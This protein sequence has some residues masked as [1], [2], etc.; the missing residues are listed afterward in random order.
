MKLQPSVLVV[1]TTGWRWSCEST[2]RSRD[3]SWVSMRLSCCNA[4]HSNGNAK[5]LSM[6]SHVHG[7]C[8]MAPASLRSVSTWVAEPRP[9]PT[10]VT[11]HRPRFFEPELLTRHPTVASRDSSADIV[12]REACIWVH[13][14]S[15]PSAPEARLAQSGGLAA[16]S[17]SLSSESESL[18]GPL[19]M[20]ASLTRSWHAGTASAWQAP[21][22]RRRRLGRAEPRARVQAAMPGAAWPLR[23]AQIL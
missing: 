1:T 5:W 15:S 4:G 10:A 22:A 9:R 2:Q 16:A 8:N 7:R 12:S 17:G 3:R 20:L 14:G 13:V 23:F 18:A 21:R 19:P 6:A 11:L